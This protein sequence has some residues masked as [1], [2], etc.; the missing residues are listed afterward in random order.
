VLGWTHE[1]Q[2]RGTESY[3][4]RLDDVTAIYEGEPGVQSALFD[5]YDVRYVYVGP[6]ERARYDLT[7][8]E[9]PR[10]EPAFESGDVVIYEIQ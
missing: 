9:H 6:A 2:Y 4:E 5:R 10:L 8:E 3:T 7:V 1:E